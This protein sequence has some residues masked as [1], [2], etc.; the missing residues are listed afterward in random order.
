MGF[1]LARSK[2]HGKDTDYQTGMKLLQ[3]EHAKG[4]VLATYEIGDLY[5]YGRGTP[6]D[7]EMA[8]QYYGIALQGFQQL[9][10]APVDP[11]EQHDRQEWLKSYL[12]YRI[13]KQLYY[14]LGTEQNYESAAEWFMRSGNAYATYMLG[15]MAYYGQG[16]ER[17]KPLAFKYYMACSSE[18]GYGAYQAAIMLDRNEVPSFPGDTLKQELY[19]S[20]FEQFHMMEKKSPSDNIE[21]RLGNMYEKGL[22]TEADMELAEYYYSLAA[23]AGNVFALNKMAGIYLKTSEME[24]VNLALDY[25][26]RA[27]TKGKSDMAAY[28][29]GKVYESKDYGVHD[30][31]KARS[32][33][34]KAEDSGNEF[35]SYRLAKI[36]CE[37]SNYKEAI[38]HFEKCHD[39]EFAYYR[40]AKIYIDPEIGMYDLEKGIGYLERAAELNFSYSQYRLG[41]IYESEEYGLQDLEKARSWYQKAEDNNNEFASYRLAKMDCEE[42]NYKGAIKHFEKCHDNEFAYYHLGAIYE[43]E[44]YG[45]QNLE[46]ARFWYQKAEDKNN[47]FASY[48]LGKMD[49]QEKNYVSAIKHLEKCNQEYSNFLLGKIYLDPDSGMVDLEKGIFYMTKS[50]DAGNSYA[51]LSLGILYLKGEIVNQDLEEAQKWFTRSASHGNEYAQNILDNPFKPY[52]KYQSVRSGVSLMSTINRMKKGLENGWQ[53]RQNIREHD[54]M[55]EQAVSRSTDHEEDK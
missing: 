48:R 14:G 2:V 39:N 28:N 50:A 10:D 49:Y 12:A 1:K 41:A 54:Q 53:K 11:V 8:D 24:K 32:W 52:G 19:E 20:A 42:S 7:L 29:L 23:D 44:E 4:N 3:V 37:E 22:G 13:G 5:Q 21:F 15:K 31:E 27:A 51:E 47:E 17:S 9:Y 46:K 33:Y 43:S 18:N 34:Q 45:L 36:D 35:A 40:L 16:M 25:L 55:V 30:M 38:K 6:I 26:T